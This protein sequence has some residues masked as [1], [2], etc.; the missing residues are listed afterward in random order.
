LP[1][2][3]AGLEGVEGAPRTRVTEDQRARLLVAA[4]DTVA[5]LGYP[6]LAVARVIRRAGVSRRTFYDAFDDR[7]DCFVALL[8]QA[9]ERVAAVVVPAYRGGARWREGIRSGLAALLDLPD[10]EPGLNRLVIS[11]ALGVGHRALERRAR[12]L[13][14]AIEAVDCGREE[15]PSGHPPPP[16]RAEGVVGAVFAILHART[17]EDPSRPLLPLLGQLMSLIALPYLGPAAAARELA[18]PAPR[19]RRT[20]TPAPVR[21]NDHSSSN[22]LEGLHM[23]LTYRTLRVLSAI[24]ATPGAS[25]RQAALRAGISDQ[26]QISKLLAR[27]QRLGLIENAG[28]GA[29]KGAPNAWTLTTRGTEIQHALTTSH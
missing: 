23:R 25:N 8:D 28:S 6:G 22:P 2:A 14:H 1:R 29:P 11:D 5:E 3:R 9:L 15:A 24:A 27:L 12:A 26:G 7:E 13:A 16:L 21:G 10:S 17:I 18:H 4:G 19:Q 20:R